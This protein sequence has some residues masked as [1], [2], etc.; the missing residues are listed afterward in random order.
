MENIL[1]KIQYQTL[2][3]CWKG[4]WSNEI[5]QK[6]HWTWMQ[7]EEHKNLKNEKIESHWVMRQYPKV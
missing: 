6:G 2:K 4:S 1:L 3:I 5:R 7:S